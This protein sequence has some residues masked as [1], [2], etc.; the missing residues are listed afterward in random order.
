MATVYKFDNKTP[1]ET[2][3]VRACCSEICTDFYDYVPESYNFNDNDKATQVHMGKNV[4]IVERK[5]L[6][7]F[8]RDNYD[9]NLE[10]NGFDNFG[11]LMM[12]HDD[13]ICIGWS[14]MVG[15]N[16]FMN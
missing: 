6:P 8:L 13:R 16:T 12:K 3:L 10:K 9:Q 7:R 1:C 11:I 2:C 15:N 14:H 5:G 4:A